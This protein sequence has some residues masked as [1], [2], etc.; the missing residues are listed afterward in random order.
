MTSACFLLTMMDKQIKLF[1]ISDTRA[2]KDLQL[3]KK[4]YT[5]D[6][7]DYKKF[8]FS[9]KNIQNSNWWSLSNT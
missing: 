4:Q 7:K 8:S 9:L 6:W 3:K 5:L 2:F 1:S